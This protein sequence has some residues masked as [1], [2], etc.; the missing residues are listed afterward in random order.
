MNRLLTLPRTAVVLV[1]VLLSGSL[2]FGECTTRVRITGKQPRTWWLDE[3]TGFEGVASV[4]VCPEDVALVAAST[5]TLLEQLGH[6]IEE[7][8]YSMLVI[9][10]AGWRPDTPRGKGLAKAC[11]EMITR[12]NRAFG[13]AVVRD[14]KCPFRSVEAF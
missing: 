11:A 3:H 2:A 6:V 9:C 7:E 14:V 13:R 5:D 12:L 4:V 10:H 8:H 1:T